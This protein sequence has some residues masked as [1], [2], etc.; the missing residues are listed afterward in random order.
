MSRISQ[1]VNRFF[2]DNRKKGIPNLMLWIAIVNAVI[3]VIAQADP[4]RALYQLL[5]FDRAMILKGQVWRLFSYVFLEMTGTGLV[6]GVLWFICYTQLGRALEN[7]W[8]RFKF[9]IYY[10]TG[11][12]LLSLG[13]MILDIPVNSFSFHVTLFLAYATIYPETV[14]H[15]FFII[16]IKARWLAIIT[17]AINLIE[18]LYFSMFPM[19]L[20]PLFGLLN[21]FL[22]MG[23]DFINV[24]P[25]SWRLNSRR[26]KRK[27]RHPREKSVP[28]HSAGSYEATK[29]TPRATYTHKCTVCGRTDVSH[30]NLEFRYCSRCKGYHCY[31]LDHINDHVHKEE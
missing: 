15:I 22:Y 28:F 4:S 13:G 30:P 3:F 25:V 5:M 21:Y 27:I 20:L 14:F 6:W 1:K 17:L 18:L 31:C 2:F 19:N 9:G 29:S 11:V 23:K 7:S 8:G 10:L 26:L 24:F 16:P 12:V